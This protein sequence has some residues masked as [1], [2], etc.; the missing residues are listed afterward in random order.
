[1][2]RV[3]RHHR[4]RVLNSKKIST[5]SASELSEVFG[6]SASS[7]QSTPAP[8]GTPGTLTPISDDKITTSTISMSAY[9]KEKMQ[10]MKSKHKWMADP[11]KPNESEPATPEIRPQSDD[12]SELPRLGLGARHAKLC[13][14]ANH[15]SLAAEPV[16]PK[17]SVSSGAALDFTPA[18]ESSDVETG[19]S[20]LIALEA[21]VPS[22]NRSSSKEK[23]KKKDKDLATHAGPGRPADHPAAQA[24]V[25]G[26]SDDEL[27]RPE[28]KRKQK[29]EST[30]DGDR[31]R[32][33]EKRRRKEKKKAKK[34]ADTEET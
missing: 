8:G 14:S 20:Q 5:K 25:T 17:T 32:K 18:P 6:I 23:K 29:L 19:A 9:F 27:S 15:P 3:Y 22:R 10:K 31:N 33:E 28:K 13:T 7:G 26:S 4:A 11:D 30:L 1:L 21:T 24:T 16:A 34:R 2:T 12:E